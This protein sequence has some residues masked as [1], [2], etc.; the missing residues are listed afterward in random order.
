[1]V[2][3]PWGCKESDKTEVTEHIDIFTGDWWTD[4]HCSE[5]DL[6]EAASIPQ[7]V[8][9]F[10]APME[11]GRGTSVH[12]PCLILTVDKICCSK[13]RTPPAHDPQNH[14]RG[15]NPL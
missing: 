8:G 14:L 13:L 2:Y 10:W 3:S 9:G 4:S 1:M 15:G 12:R 5:L 6:Q 7:V 11:L